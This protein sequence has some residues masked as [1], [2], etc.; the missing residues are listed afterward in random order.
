MNQMILNMY[1]IAVQSKRISI[2]FV[3]NMYRGKVIEAIEDEG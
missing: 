2:E 3:P 1:I